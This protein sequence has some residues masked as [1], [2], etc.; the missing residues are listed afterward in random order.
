MAHVQSITR[1][2]ESGS[3]LVWVA[4]ILMAVTSF[5]YTSQAH[6]WNDASDDIN[7]TMR[8]DKQGW[9]SLKAYDTT[10]TPLDTH[11]ESSVTTAVNP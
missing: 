2:D 6:A 10:H 8:P 9:L 11:E 5:L 3:F 4:P 1:K 7:T